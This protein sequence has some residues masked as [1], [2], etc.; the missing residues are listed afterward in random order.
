[1]KSLGD[2][3][4]GQHH[5]KCSRKSNKNIIMFELMKSLTKLVSKKEELQ[6]T[7]S[8]LSFVPSKILNHKPWWIVWKLYYSHSR[9]KLEIN[10][11]IFEQSWKNKNIKLRFKIMREAK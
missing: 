1:M 2:Y 7:L 9:R 5:V 11:E 3:L 10:N 4:C 6:V 8:F